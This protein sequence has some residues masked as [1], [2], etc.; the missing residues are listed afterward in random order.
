MEFVFE[1]L[2]DL[3]LEGSIELSS[4]KKISKFI[5]YP[6]ICLIVLFFTTIIFLIFFLGLS[7]LNE[8]ILA[9]LIIMGIS[10]VMAILGIFKFKKMYLERKDNNG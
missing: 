8:N 9:S 7:L 3:I 1:F 10:F 5:R 2:L 4:N 6:L